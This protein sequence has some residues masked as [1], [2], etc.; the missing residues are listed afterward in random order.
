MS[1][2]QLDGEKT[3]ALAYMLPSSAR[4]AH[5]GCAP[6][7]VR[8]SPVEGL[9]SI[10]SKVEK[11]HDRSATNIQPQA[12]LAR[13]AWNE[14]ARR[15]GHRG[16]LAHSMQDAQEMPAAECLLLIGHGSSQP[17]L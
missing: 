11:S 15:G 4:D 9:A 17:C 7:P 1:A 12:S 14:P 10:T 6:E 3:S 5:A 2:M 13:L 16:E 8:A